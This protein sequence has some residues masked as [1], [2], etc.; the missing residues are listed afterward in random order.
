MKKI[1]QI[2]NNKAAEELA[3][4]SIAQ[5]EQDD[6][7]EQLRILRG[8][9]SNLILFQGLVLKLDPTTISELGIKEQL[10]FINE[11]ILIIEKDFLTP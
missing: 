11:D 2:D 5:E 7:K 1:Q 10:E 9:K 8:M 4:L 3:A 6:F